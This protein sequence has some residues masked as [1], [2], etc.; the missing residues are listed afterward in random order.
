VVFQPLI[1]LQFAHAEPT[2]MME[3]M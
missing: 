3:M 1:L 2:K